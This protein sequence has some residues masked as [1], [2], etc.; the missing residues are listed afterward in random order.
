M[1]EL[2][3]QQAMNI[4]DA[5]DCQFKYGYKPNPFC[6]KCGGAGKLH[7]KREDGIVDYSVLVLCDAP[8]CLRESYSKH[9]LQMHGRSL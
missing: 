6:E 7:P 3:S 4:M 5:N 8:N 1:A 9:E 2:T